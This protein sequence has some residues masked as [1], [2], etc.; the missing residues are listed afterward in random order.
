VSPVGTT[1]WPSPPSIRALGMWAALLSGVG[2]G[3]LALAGAAL[4]QWWSQRRDRNLQIWSRRADAYV[5]LMRWRLAPPDEI[6][7]A[8]PR[9]LAEATLEWSEQ[10][11]PLLAELSLFGGPALQVI[12]TRTPYLHRAAQELAK[13][14]P[15]QLSTLAQGDLESMRRAPRV[16]RFPD[17]ARR[18]P[19][20]V[21]TP[22]ELQ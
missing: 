12:L 4:T 17:R 15:T 6:A 13:L 5:A 21:A 8:D 19:E 3:A 7:I 10:V 2:G 18:V 22:G 20:R 16:P 11:Y 1:A 14:T 9:L